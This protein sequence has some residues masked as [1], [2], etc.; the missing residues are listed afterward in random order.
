MRIKFSLLSKGSEFVDIR[1]LKN[2]LLS[3]LKNGRLFVYDDKAGFLVDWLQDID[4]E[5]Q[6]ELMRATVF[7]K[8]D[9]K[10]VTPSEIAQEQ[11]IKTTLITIL[12]Q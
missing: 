7:N 8:A 12:N 3:V 6:K 2:V 10:P 5:Q 9:L 11:D 1:K 4:W